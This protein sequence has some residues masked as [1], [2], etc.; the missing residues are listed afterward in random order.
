MPYGGT[1]VYS[2][3]LDGEWSEAR[4]ILRRLAKRLYCVEWL[5]VDG[6]EAWWEALIGDEEGVD[7]KGSWGRVRIVAMRRGDEVWG[8]IGM[9]VG[10]PRRLEAQVRKKRGW[11]DVWRDEGETLDG[12]EMWNSFMADS[13]QS[14][15][16]ESRAR[17]GEGDWVWD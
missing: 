16:V 10:V 17:R 4:G 7:W 1:N 15:A 6:C 8:R 3:T 11:F 13:R 2:H 12:D 9:G 5:D 14:R